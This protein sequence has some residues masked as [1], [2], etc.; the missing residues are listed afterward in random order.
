MCNLIRWFSGITRWPLTVRDGKS[1]CAIFLT[2]QLV[3]IFRP[4]ARKT[5]CEECYTHC[6]ISTR[7]I[8]T[9]AISIDSAFSCY[10]QIFHSFVGYLR[11]FV[12]IFLV[13]IFLGLSCFCALLNRFS[14][15]CQLWW[16]CFSI[17]YWVTAWLLDVPPSMSKKEEHLDFHISAGLPSSHHH[18]RGPSHTF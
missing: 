6:I 3:L 13:L 2:S 11:C 9:S 18:Q 10:L 1:V 4:R 5:M 7:A 16:F 15:L 12:A 8:S 17:Y 14:H